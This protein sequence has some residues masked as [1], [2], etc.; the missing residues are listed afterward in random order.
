MVIVFI[1]LLTVLLPFCP[2]WIGVHNIE[3]QTWS[4]CHAPLWK[5]IAHR[6]MVKNSHEMVQ[7]LNYKQVAEMYK[8]RIKE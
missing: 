2:T 8:H 7:I 1:V 4:I 6:I 5:V 3:R